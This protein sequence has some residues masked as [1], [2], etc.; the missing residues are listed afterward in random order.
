MI[1][2]LQ[3]PLNGGNPAVARDPI[4]QVEAVTGISRD[5][6]RIVPLGLELSAYADLLPTASGVA[7]T[8][9]QPTIGYLARLAEEKGLHV[10]VDAFI[11]LRE[12]TE[13][14]ARL[15]IAGWLGQQ[16]EAYAEAQFAK[17]RDA[18][19]ADAFHY[20]GEVDRAGKMQF[21][22]EIDVLSVPT[23]YKEPK[24]L[25]VLE[26]LA[27]GVPVVQPRH[28]AFPELLER[29]GGGKLVEA[30]DAVALAEGLAELLGQEE[31][32]RELG[33][34]GQRAVH[35]QFHARAMA[36]QTLAVMQRFL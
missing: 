31:T 6:F 36:E 29:T 20:A 22:R 24:G 8:T 35:E 34:A 12:N 10:L 26:A 25:F 2:L 21:L 30:N 13:I 15:Q 1:S 23:V 16:Q 3:N 32:R 27:A 33:C 4:M 5:K 28:G 7:R 11:H 19:L 14:D 18:G 17:L 9:R